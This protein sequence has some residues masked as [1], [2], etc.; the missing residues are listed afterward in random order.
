MKVKEQEQET[1]IFLASL[2]SLAPRRVPQINVMDANGRGG[3][4]YV[5]EEEEAQE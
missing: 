5:L 1:T 2:N 3:L 4:D